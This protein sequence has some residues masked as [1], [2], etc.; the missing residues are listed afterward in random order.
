MIYLI[1]LAIVDLETAN[2]VIITLAH[3][4]RSGNGTLISKHVS[5]RGSRMRIACF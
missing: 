4:Q 2:M 1:E 5:M 3:A